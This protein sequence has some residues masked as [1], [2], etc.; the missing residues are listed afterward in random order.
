P[1]LIRTFLHMK[2]QRLLGDHSLVLAG[3]VGW[4]DQGI[5]DAIAQAGDSI[6]QIGYAR[7]D[8]L[9]ALYSGSDAFIFPSKYEGFGMPVLEAPSRGTRVVT[10]D[11]PE[12]REAGGKVATYITPT[13]EGLRA[14]IL[15]ALASP[16]PKP[17]PPG[18]H[19]WTRSASV[20]AAVF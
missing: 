6:R 11:I 14:G 5:A 13:E 19:S 4:K 9:P 2:E 17:L 20:M 15:Q 16:R 10:T 18:S 12:L 3:D 1:L 7:E 8:Q